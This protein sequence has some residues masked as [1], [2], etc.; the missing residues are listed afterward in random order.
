MR[1]VDFEEAIHDFQPCKH[2]AT[3]IKYICDKHQMTRQDFMVLLE[4]SALEHFTWEDFATAELTASWDKRRFYRWKDTGL[5][6][7][8]RAKDGKFQRYNIYKCTRR[9]RARVREFYDLLS[10]KEE[11]PTLAFSENAKYSSNRLVRK[12]NKLKD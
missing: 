4:V 12:I 7:L 11:L 8:Y 3:I 10:G 1:R 5:V 6:E 9:A 2:L